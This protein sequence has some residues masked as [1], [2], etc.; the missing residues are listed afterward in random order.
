MQG[1]TLEYETVIVGM[2]YL[3]RHGSFY[4]TITHGC[5]SDQNVLLV[6]EEPIILV[7]PSLP[8]PM[9]LLSHFVGPVPL[10]GCALKGNHCDNNQNEDKPSATRFDE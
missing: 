6:K 10:C 5:I 4:T 3:K 2:E 1:Q 8:M 7:P 9:V